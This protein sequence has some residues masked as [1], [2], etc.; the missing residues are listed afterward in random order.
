[1]CSDMV[2]MSSMTGGTALGDHK[3]SHRVCHSIACLKVKQILLRRVK[4]KLDVLE[5]HLIHDHFTVSGSIIR[6]VPAT[7]R[8]VPDM[9]TASPPL[10]KISSSCRN[11]PPFQHLSVQRSI[12]FWDVLKYTFQ[13]LSCFRH[14]SLRVSKFSRIA[15]GHN[16]RI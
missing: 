3:N 10:P 8:L 14:E 6:E 1:M 15:S 9:N 13:L 12:A 5:S 11:L 4:Y 2:L 16:S 7:Y